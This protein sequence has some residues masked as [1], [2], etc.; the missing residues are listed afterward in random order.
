VKRA[1]KGCAC[2]VCPRSGSSSASSLKDWLERPQSGDEVLITERR[3]PVAHLNGID[4]A[5]YLGRL[6]EQGISADPPDLICG[7]L[8]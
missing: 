8:R 3:R 4:I 1:K 5:P 6:V 2:P 7:V